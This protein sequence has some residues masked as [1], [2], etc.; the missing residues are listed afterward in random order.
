MLLLDDSHPLWEV[1]KL[2]QALHAAGVAL[3]SRT[4]E[5][6]AFAMHERAFSLWGLHCRKKTL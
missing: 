6:D 3:W 5:T 2:K 4:V 1:E